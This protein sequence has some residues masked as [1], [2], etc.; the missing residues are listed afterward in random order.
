MSSE[1]L[2]KERSSIKKIYIVSSDLC[3][4]TKKMLDQFS[5]HIHLNTKDWAVYQIEG[6]KKLHLV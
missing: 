6:M 1:Y 2:D 4:A 3:N 5:F